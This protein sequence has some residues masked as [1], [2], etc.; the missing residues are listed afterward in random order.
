MDGK[1]DECNSKVGFVEW[2]F[3]ERSRQG[4]DKGRCNAWKVLSRER[5]LAIGKGVRLVESSIERDL[6]KKRIDRVG[7]TEG[8]LRG[9]EVKG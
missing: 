3:I 6:I 2:G 1:G 9:R 4:V 8:G 7:L 5:G